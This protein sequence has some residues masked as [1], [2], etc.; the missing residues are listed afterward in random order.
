MKTKN[1]TPTIS[2]MQD[3]VT[4]AEGLGLNGLFGGSAQSDVHAE[5]R[6]F[7]E[8]S[9]E[10]LIYIMP[11]WIGNPLKRAKVHNLAQRG[12][13]SLIALDEA[14][15]YHYWQDFRSACIKGF[16][17]FKVRILRNT[18]CMPDCYCTSS[19]QAKLDERAKKSCCVTR[20]H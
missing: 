8:D 13:L 4:N 20:E 19:C 10:Q 12:K 1:K 7:S 9:I 2:L 11:E 5:D 16:A 18:I 3:R 14:H 15:L 6:A 17:T